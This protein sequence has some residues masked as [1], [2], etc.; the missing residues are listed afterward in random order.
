M[1]TSKQIPG[2]AANSNTTAIQVWGNIIIAVLGILATLTLLR[3]VLQLPKT[4]ISPLAIGFY[5]VI[6]LAGFGVILLT[7]R[8]HQKSGARLAFYATVALFA[9]GPFFYTGR[10]LAASS[11]LIMVS[12][13]TISQLLPKESRR[14]SIVTTGVALMG[15]WI[16]EWIDPLWRLLP[17]TANNVGIVASILFALTLAVI[18]LRQTWGGNIRVKVVAS[19][20]AIALISVALVGTV[21][22][23]SYR[24][25]VREDIRQRLLNIIS[26]TA[27]QQDGDLFATIQT[28]EDMQGESYQK[29]ETVNHAILATDLDLAYIF[30]VR[31]DEHGTLTF[32]VD[33]GLEEGYA[34]VDVG[35]VYED[36][37]QLLAENALTL[38]HPVVEEDFYTD[39]YGTFLSAYAPIYKSDGTRAGIV[40]VDI[41]ADKVLAEERAILLTILGTTLGTMIIVILLG[42]WLGNLFVS[43]VIDLSNVAKRITEGDLSARAEIET[44]DEVGALANALNQMTSQLQTTLQGLEQRVAARTRNLE[45]AADVGRAISQVSDLHTMLENACELILKEFNLYYVQVY[46]TAASQKSLTLEAGTGEVGAQLVRREHSLPLNNNSINGR[47]AVEKHSIVISDTTESLTFRKNPLLPETRGEMAVPLII[48]DQVVGVLDMQSS[49]AGVLNQEVLPA[50]EAL[51]GQLAVAIQN[52]KLLQETNEAR[53]EVEKQARRLAR[54]SWN[55]YLDA[56]HKPEEIGFVFGQNEVIPLVGS[57]E[58]QVDENAISSSISFTGER[59]GSLSVQMDDSSRKD[60]ALELVNAV[61]QRMAQQIE[62]L[63]LLENAERYRQQAELAVRRTT[64]EGWEQFMQSQEQGKIVYRYDTREVQPV[65]QDPETASLTLAIKTREQAIGKVSILGSEE[66]DRASLEIVNSVVERLGDHIESLRQYD[67]T[68]NALAQSETLFQASTQMSQAMSLQE[69]VAAVVTT[70]DIPAANRALLTNFQYG[71]S[72]EIEELTIIGNWW[73]GTGHEVTPIGT[74]YSREVMR[75]MP[76]FIS[77]TPVFFDDVFNDKRVDPTTLELVAKRLNL[78]SVAVLPLYSANKQ[79]GALVLEGEEP[80]HFT[81]Q[82]TR[83]FSSLAPQI[84]TIMENRRQYEETQL[85]RAQSEKLF[86][87]SSQLT[88]VADLQ[89]LVKV[90]AETM[91]IPIVN[92]VVL[93]LFNYSAASNLEGMNVAATWW[94]GSGNEPTPLGTHYTTETLGIMKLFLTPTP[95][96]FSDALTDERFDQTARQIAQNLSVRSGA[97]LPLHA[98]SRQVGV[99]FMQAE[100][101]HTF[102]REEIRLFEALAPQISTVLENRRQYEMAQRQAQRETMLNAINQKIQSATT[103]EAVLQIAAREL[104]HALG[105]PLTIAQL[106][107]KPNGNGHNGNA[108]TDSA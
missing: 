39:Q 65:S 59:L 68:Q 48:A 46:L 94:N 103:V 105:A 106:G 26:I 30:S 62:N 20:T 27:L 43:P 78:R 79:I 38:D 88:Q 4:M 84:A 5:I 96:F 74:R 18:I 49:E 83:L 76:M 52:A 89:Q 42:W 24:N 58:F 22:Y 69:L 32:V 67:Q 50:F 87:A 100:E 93:D 1:H 23:F 63:R 75:V 55:E 33:S 40:G 6:L 77:P 45:L 99:L 91:N 102:T 17:S 82:E 70:L 60:Q 47:A 90:V 19:F 73:N 92:R 72:G 80:H 56:V 8:G 71:P 35:V 95:L 104:G 25:Q 86:T 41:F 64:L 21:V 53:A 61:V 34:P 15:M 13:I 16:I 107:L 29:M 37:S 98:G 101:P 3:S 12:A 31:V 44:G 36:P 2:Q 10:A 11:L 28:P 97:V 85:A 51:A 9:S 7:L 54:T 108:G 14:R 66:P 81:Q 57:N